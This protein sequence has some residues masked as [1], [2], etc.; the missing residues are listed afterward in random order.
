MNLSNP[1]HL[2]DIQ[3]FPLKSKNICDHCMGNGFIFSISTKR[4]NMSYLEICS[5]IEAKCICDKKPP[6][7]YYDIKSHE[8]KACPCRNSRN[9]INKIKQLFAESNIPTKYR[10][11][12]IDEFDTHHKDSNVE[13]CLIEAV[14]NAYHFLQEVK[15]IQEEFI[16]GW[17]FYGRPGSGKTL[18]GCLILNECIYRYQIPVRYLKITRDFLNRLKSSYNQE[19]NLYGQSEDIFTLMSQIDILLLD[20]FGVQKDSP[21]EQ[22]TLYELIDTRYEFEKPTLITSNLEPKEISSLFQGRIHS[23]L[24]EMVRTQDL[25]VPDYRDNFQN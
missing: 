7:M 22:R 10:Y 16:R 17:H 11:R 21:W 4:K 25:T 1:E 15:N 18:L 13:N 9:K 19:S 6:Y 23:R 14:D 20:D 12:L 2:P 8:L 24:K 3:S 5:C